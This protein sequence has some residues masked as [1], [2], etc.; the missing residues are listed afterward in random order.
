LAVFHDDGQP[1]AA[2]RQQPDIVQRIT[3]KPNQVGRS[4]L[5]DAAEEDV[6]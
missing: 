1:R 4:P 6:S 5:A 2:L 3:V